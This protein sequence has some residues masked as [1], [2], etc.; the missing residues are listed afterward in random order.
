MQTYRECS[1]RY[2]VAITISSAA[3]MA[4]ASSTSAAGRS[5]PKAAA[6]RARTARP[7][8]VPIR[9]PTTPAAPPTA[10][11][12]SPPR[13]PPPPPRPS[14]CTRRTAP[15]PCGCPRQL[16]DDELDKCQ[17]RQDPMRPGVAEKSDPGVVEAKPPEIYR[18]P[19]GRRLQK[20]RADRPRGRSARQAHRRSWHCSR[21]GPRCV[22]PI[23]SVSPAGAAS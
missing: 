16:I 14:L 9:A 21:S 4:T 6:I 15:A 3:R 8:S 20:G 13:A 18:P 23:I 7:P 11:A 5:R 12:R 19:D 22:A 10:A 2:S 17:Q 1:G